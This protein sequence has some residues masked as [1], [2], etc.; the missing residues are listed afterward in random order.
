MKGRGFLHAPAGRVISVISRQSQLLGSMSL[1]ISGAGIGWLAGLAVTPVVSIVITSVTG[2]AAAIITAISGIRVKD[3]LATEESHVW[4]QAQATPLPLALLITGLVIGSVV[5]ITARNNH[6]MGS[7]LSSELN[8]WEALGL[9]RTEVVRRI[10]EV[11]YPYTPYARN[12]SLLRMDFA[13]ELNAWTGITHTVAI[14]PND[15][16]AKRLFELDYAVYEASEATNRVSISRDVDHANP[17]PSVLFTATI[18]ECNYL[19]AAAVK[20][21]TALVTALQTS[22]IEQWRKLPDLVKDSDS[23]KMIIEEV[24]CAN[25]GG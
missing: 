16:I 13:T 14:L 19:T 8:Q 4:R 25:S 23:L 22:T 6:W 1:I 18:K 17:G 2:I 3:Y 10:F 20:S 7:S 24:L 11:E 15:E 9:D 12:A 21:K 5:G